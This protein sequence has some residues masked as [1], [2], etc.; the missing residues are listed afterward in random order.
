MVTY[1]F[2]FFKL[3]LGPNAVVVGLV[4]PKVCNVGVDAGRRLTAFRCYKSII[5]AL[6]SSLVLDE[7]P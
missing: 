5:V 2:I 7:C 1:G 6:I 3:I 4:V